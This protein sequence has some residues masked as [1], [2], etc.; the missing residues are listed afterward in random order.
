[1]YN[2]IIGVKYMREYKG[3]EHMV[4]GFKREIDKKED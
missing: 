1:M 4:K 3:P 2:S